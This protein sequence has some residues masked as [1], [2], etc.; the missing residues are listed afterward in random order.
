[1]CNRVL[2]LGPFLSGQVQEKEDGDSKQG[3]ICD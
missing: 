3:T 2:K 1:M